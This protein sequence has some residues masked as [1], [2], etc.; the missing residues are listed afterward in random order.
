MKEI[1]LPYGR[2]ALPL[3][4]EENRLEALMQARGL[5]TVSD[6]AQAGQEA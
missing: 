6:A 3:H 4:I 1:L 2:T 5:P